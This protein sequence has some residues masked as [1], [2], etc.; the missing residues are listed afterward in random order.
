MQEAKKM[1]KEAKAKKKKKKYF[2][3]KRKLGVSMGERGSLR[4]VMMQRIILLKM[5]L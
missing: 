1:K 5:L 2:K 4:R 3:L